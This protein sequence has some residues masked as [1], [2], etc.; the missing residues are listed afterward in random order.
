MAAN[1]Q[2]I[3]TRAG[4]NLN[5]V[6]ALDSIIASFT[7]D[8]TSGT[9]IP[10]ALIQ[11]VQGSTQAPLR[12]IF[13]INTPGNIGNIYYAVTR[14]VAS[15]AMSRM[16]GPANLMSAFF[17]KFG[18]AC[19]ARTN[20]MS[21]GATASDCSITGPNQPVGYTATGCVLENY[22]FSLQAEQSLMNENLQLR[23][24]NLLYTGP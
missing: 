12:T 21:F 5:G 19:A 2:P 3:F 9:T 23:V 6:F 10:A 20:E 14:A 16:V 13:E 15:I 24:S 1:G 7:S 22:G 11:S 18:D 4:N 8:A 17:K